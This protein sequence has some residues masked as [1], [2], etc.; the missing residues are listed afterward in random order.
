M[1]LF[2]GS[3]IEAFLLGAMF[4]TA[5]LGVGQFVMNLWYMFH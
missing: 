2:R 1:E 4:M 5:V 3:A